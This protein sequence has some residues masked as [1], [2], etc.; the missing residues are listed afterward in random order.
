[1]CLGVNVPSLTSASLPSDR[2]FACGIRCVEVRLGVGDGEDCLLGLHGTE[3]FVVVRP[4]A[5]FQGART[6]RDALVGSP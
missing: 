5:E 3:A 6:V 4:N 2:P 1:M